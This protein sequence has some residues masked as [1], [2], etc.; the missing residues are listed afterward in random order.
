MYKYNTA[1]LGGN[2]LVLIRPRKETSVVRQRG[3]SPLM[4][5]ALSGPSVSSS[6]DERVSLFV[7]LELQGEGWEGGREMD[8]EQLPTIRR[9]LI[10]DTLTESN[11]NI[12]NKGSG[13]DKEPLITHVPDGRQR[14]RGRGVVGLDAEKQEGA[15]VRLGRARRSENTR[16]RGGAAAHLFAFLLSVKKDKK[17]DKCEIWKTFLGHTI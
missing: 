11:G 1:E 12:E 8:G 17:R 2:R 15:S 4:T 13:A 7:V 14:R 10:S 9:L 5:A 6:D 3:G 16:L